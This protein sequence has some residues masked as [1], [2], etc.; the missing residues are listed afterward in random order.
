MAKTNKTNKSSNALLTAAL[1]ILVGVL[2][3]I[4]KGTVLSW[5]FTV[6]GVL[7]LVQGVLS[8]LAKDNIAGA[9]SL[10]IGLVLLIGGWTIVE[11]ILIVFGILMLVKGGTGLLTLLNGKPSAMQ[12][13]TM[14]GTI[15]IGIL[16]IVSRW[17]I[18]DWFFIIMGVFFI[19]DGVVALLG[20]WNR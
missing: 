7:F 11:I 16:L 12:L 19:V 3:C 17:V 8:I 2:F 9:I 4:L 5:L 10:V 15:L 6:V 13:I 18:F 14:A 20:A 1:Y